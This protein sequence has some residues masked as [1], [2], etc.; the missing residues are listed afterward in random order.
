MSG[1]KQGDSLSATLFNI[2]LNSAIKSLNVRGNILYKLTQCL[3]Y[4]D[5][6]ALIARNKESLEEI[7]NKLETSSKVTGLQINEK[8][9]KYLKMSASE[10]RRGIQTLK[11]NDYNL[12]GDGEFTYLGVNINNSSNISEEIN[13]RLMKGNKAYYAN[14]PLLKSTLV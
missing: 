11:I 5:D 13:T 8:Q 10:T 4:A 7:F 1:V 6:I 12:K 14:I 3:A 9:T 2:A